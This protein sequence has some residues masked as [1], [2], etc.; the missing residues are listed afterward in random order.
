MLGCL[1]VRAT[2]ISK[3]TRRHGKDAPAFGL[4]QNAGAILKRDTLFDLIEMLLRDLF[5]RT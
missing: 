3:Q 2:E 1:P 4:C 5:A